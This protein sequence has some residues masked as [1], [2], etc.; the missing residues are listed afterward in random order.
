MF[1]HCQPCPSRQGRP[2]VRRVVCFLV[3]VL[4]W[5]FA[6]GALAAQA[7]AM[8]FEDEDS[9]ADLRPVLTLGVFAFRPKPII[10]ERFAELGEYLAQHLDGYRVRVS[11][12]TDIE[13][14]QAMAE[15]VLDFVLTNPT[16]YVILRE[17]GKLSG[18]LASMVLRDGHTPV[19]G[20]GG[21]IVRRADRSDLNGLRDLRGRRVAIAGKTFLG[22]Y[23]APAAELVRAGIALD[24]ITFIESAQPVDQVITAVLE[25]R[26]D[27]GFVRTGV[28]EDLEREG[29]LQP[30]DL[31]V[32]QPQQMPGFPYRLSTRL[33]PEWPFLAAAHVPPAVSHR[34]AAALLSLPAP[35]RAAQQAGIYGFTIPADY[36][37]VEQA[38]RDLRMAPFDQVPPPAWSDVWQRYR[39]W[40]VTLAVAGVLVLG[41]TLVLAWNMRRL[42]LA[43]THLQADR[44]KL[45]AHQRELDRLAHYDALTGVPNRR[46]LEERMS[47]AVARAR[48]SGRLLAVCY[49]DLDDFKPVNDRLGHAMGDR[50]LIEITRRLQQGL[51]AEDTL[52]RLGGDE[53]VVL[54][55]D[56]QND[57]EWEVV[58]RRL[59]EQ[60]QQPVV[61]EAH[62]AT[63]SVSA[64]VT[65]F[66]L[67]DADPDTLLRHADQAMYRAK[68]AGRNRFHLFDMT[69]DRELQA[70]HEQVLRLGEALRRGEFVLHY[71]PQVDLR[72]GAVLGV[73]A[74]IRWQHPQ[75][76]LLPP[77][78]FLS[79]LAGTAL[80]IELGQWVIDTA[81]RQCASW[82]AHDIGLP[83]QACVSVNIEGSLLLRPGFSQWLAELLQ[84][85]PPGMARCLELEVL[86]SVALADV[87]TAAGVM[88][89]CRALGVRFA[90]DD[91]GTG[92][93]S[94]AYFRTLPLDQVKIDKGFVIN[95]LDQPDDRNIVESVTFLAHA[96][97]RPVL[98]EGVETPEHAALLL[99]LGCHLAQGYAIARPMPAQALAGWLETWRRDRPWRQWQAQALDVID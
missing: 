47:R 85:H 70:Q 63:V 12:M 89:D 82:R 58:L 52:A 76:G 95:M 92:Y 68:Q 36:S 1:T 25:G 22:T 59:M 7:W 32:I 29:R 21:V 71:Q 99:R 96:F 94:L 39:P 24:S 5:V 69:V 19:Y 60:V 65:L 77:A 46:L 91:F 55:G 66:P 45:R 18:A 80:E 14:E 78:Q 30:G 57:T 37:S 35:H 44:V 3:P 97:E 2:L 17:H 34:V 81:L 10:D 31:M 33:Y 8:P 73:E 27:A 64:G 11:A 62:T 61:M 88:V 83:A 74:L 26:A 79:R 40:I 13:L 98:A 87:A 50:F 41:L 67:D 28:L 75:Q 42:M 9:L 23:M 20:I 54:L 6:A 43:K 53:F 51:R 15:G 4:A 84:T 90:L 38:M 48:R 16:H 49:L 93:S 72:T 56:L 86:E